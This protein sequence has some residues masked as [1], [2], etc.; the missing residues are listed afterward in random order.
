MKDTTEL[1][2]RV[3]Q[4]ESE[5]EKVK[6]ELAPPKKGFFANWVRRPARFVTRHWSVILSLSI[7]L[8]IYWKYGIGYFEPQKNTALAKRTSDSYVDLGEKLLLN[9]E[10]PAAKEAYNAA[11][12]VNPNNVDATRGMLTIDV[13]E[14]LPG[15]K[16]GIPE[17]QEAKVAHLYAVLN[18]APEKSLLERLKQFLSGTKDEDKTYIVSYFRGLLAEQ[19]RNYPEAKKEYQASVDRRPDFIAGYIALAFDH[20][21][22]GDSVDEPIK[23]LKEALKKNERSAIALNNLAFCYVLKLKFEEARCLYE[24]AERISPYLDTYVNLADTYRLRGDDDNALLYHKH[25]LDLILDAGAEKEHA[26]AG[27]MVINFMPKHVGD[28][29]TTKDYITVRTMKEKKALIKYELSLDYALAGD[30]KKA[31]TAFDEASVLDPDKQYDKFM[32]N[33]TLSLVKFRTMS[34]KTERWLKA[35]SW[36]DADQRVSRKT[37][38][39]SSPSGGACGK[40]SDILKEP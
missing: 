16:Y 20:I 27:I 3:H 34:R 30:L 11:L 19:Q 7:A 8:F 10:F 36:L 6:N 9:G 37:Q 32:K 40:I 12:K 26:V 2:E 14:P 38:S 21:L 5:I 1:L 18:K 28:T 39:D 35:R 15:Q 4:L 24:E 29:E 23:T 33:K 22:A 25:G 17:V 31:Q 13:M